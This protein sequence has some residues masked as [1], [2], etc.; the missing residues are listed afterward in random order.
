MSRRRSEGPVLAAQA[1]HD[2]NWRVRLLDERGA[3]LGA[4]FSV[5]PYHS[6]QSVV[7]ESAGGSATAEYRRA[8]E[9]LLRR[10]RSVGA[11]LTDGI[12]DSRVTRALPDAER[13]LVLRHGRK[14]PISLGTV[15]VE[16]LRLAIGAAQ[17]HVG[18]RAGATAGNRTKRI[19]LMVQA[20]AS[21]LP[22]DL[23]GFLSTGHSA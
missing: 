18:Q 17:E 13:R 5:E 21:P 15:D 23:E 2:D 8:L 6:V 20:G 4:R 22:A 7:L 16:E 1:S 3:L 12:V 11:V 10:L 9:L 19:R 14:Y